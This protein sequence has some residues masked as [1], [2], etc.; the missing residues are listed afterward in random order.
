MINGVLLP[1]GV[2]I[3]S[4]KA[5]SKGITNSVIA[6]LSSHIADTCQSCTPCCAAYY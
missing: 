4:D 3:R 2:E 6:G 1:S 5:P